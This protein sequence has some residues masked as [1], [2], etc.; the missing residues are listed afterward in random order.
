MNFLEAVLS[1]FLPTPGTSAWVLFAEVLMALIEHFLLFCMAIYALVL[2]R[3]VWCTLAAL[4]QQDRAPARVPLLKRT[5]IRFG[6]VYLAWW[7][8]FAVFGY[9]SDATY[10]RTASN[11]KRSTSPEYAALY[12]AEICYVNGRENDI[13]SL[14]RIYDAKTTEIIAEEFVLHAEGDVTWEN[15]RLLDQVDKNGVLVI[16]PSKPYVRA[17]GLPLVE[18]NLPPSWLDRMRAKLP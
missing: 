14:L 16:E 18:I 12:F 1:H 15:T 10:R 9:W 4:T 5:V 2:V 7:V 6:G 8:V 13:R 11:C 3:R 17:W